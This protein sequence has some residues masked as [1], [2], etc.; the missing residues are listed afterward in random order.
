M[1]EPRDG[2][3]D[4]LRAR[5]APEHVVEGGIERLVARWERT[6]REIEAG[7]DLEIEDYLNDVDGRQLIAELLAGAELEERDELEA[8]VAIADARARERLV[9]AGGCLWGDELAA[10]RGLDPAREWWYFELPAERAADP[11]WRP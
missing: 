5:G 1:S 2:V 9:P 4:L 10:S 8:R 7:Y 6:S 3:R 11:G